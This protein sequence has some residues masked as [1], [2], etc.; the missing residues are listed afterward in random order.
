MAE[1][2]LQPTKGSLALTLFPCLG[3]II[4]VKE[5]YLPRHSVPIKNQLSLHFQLSRLLDSCSSLAVLGENTV[6]AN[7]SPQQPLRYL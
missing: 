2:A 5:P 3:L 6:L 4:I 1:R 7:S